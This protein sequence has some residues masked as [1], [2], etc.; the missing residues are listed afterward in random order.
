MFT[1]QKVLVTD[2]LLKLFVAGEA[3]EEQW[4]TVYVCCL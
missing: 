4:F 1:W 3:V 2:E